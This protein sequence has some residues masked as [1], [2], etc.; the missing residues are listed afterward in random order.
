MK[1]AVEN[2]NKGPLYSE[3]LPTDWVI[4]TALPFLGKFV[5]TP[6]PWSPPSTQFLD[7][8]V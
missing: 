3:S 5:S 7:N 1:Y 2:P 6:T 8:V 4:Q